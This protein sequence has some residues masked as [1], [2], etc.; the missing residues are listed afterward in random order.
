M[1]WFDYA[2]KI[3][4]FGGEKNDEGQGAPNYYIV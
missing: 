2:V 4:G 3:G 1:L